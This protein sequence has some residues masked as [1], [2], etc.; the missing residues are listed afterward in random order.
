VVAAAADPAVKNVKPRRR[1]VYIYVP[2]LPLMLSQSMGSSR[3]GGRRVMRLFI[4]WFI[5]EKLVCESF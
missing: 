4:K 2:A 1:L 3:P 5:C